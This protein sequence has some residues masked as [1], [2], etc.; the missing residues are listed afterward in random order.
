MPLQTLLGVGPNGSDQ[1]GNSVIP[2]IM[3][4]PQVEAAFAGD[5]AYSKW[6]TKPANGMSGNTTAE[7][8]PGFEAP[9]ELMA[10]NS[11]AMQSVCATAV[12]RAGLT[13]NGAAY[14]WGN[15]L[16]VILMAVLTSLQS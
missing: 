12:M 6:L 10:Y 15:V 16:K 8:I 5:A 3:Q 2:S 14:M 1:V 11:T 9:G 4:I 7:A 13:E